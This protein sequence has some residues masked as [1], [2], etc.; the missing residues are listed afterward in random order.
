MK[1]LT[2]VLLSTLFNI[3]VITAI[4][5]Q[6]VLI[7]QPGP[8]EGKDAMLHGLSNVSNTNFGDFDDFIAFAWTFQGNPG[9]GRSLMEFDLSTLP[10]DILITNAT[11]S[12]YANPTSN[13]GTHSTLSGPNSCWIR[14]IV[15]P[16]EEST[17][18]WNTQPSATTENQ[19]VLPSSVNPLQDYLDVNVT[20][21]VNDMINDPENSFGFL[22]QLQTEEYYR[23]MTFASSD[24][25]DVSKRPMIT[26]EYLI[27]GPNDTC[28]VIQPGAEEG[29]DA[30]LH[31]LNYLTNTNFGNH[32]DYIASTWTFQ[33]DPGTIRS[34][35]DFDLSQI[36]PSAG[37]S[38]ASLSL[39]ANPTSNMGPHSSL[40]GSNKSLLQR[41]TTTIFSS[42][43]AIS[44]TIPSIWPRSTKE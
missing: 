14:R 30:L 5:S 4:N 1:N 31:G 10:A 33:G 15:N 11:L 12:L 17:V 37:I 8:D 22:L 25:D 40:S 39:Y 24:H 42:W 21:L 18:T 2:S 28:I 7:L 38:Y 6:N 3:I 36:P 34:V 13:M 32:K 9:T 19:V 41:I 20:T 44:P 27:P 29:K 23:R 43:I 26:I 35:M 16:W